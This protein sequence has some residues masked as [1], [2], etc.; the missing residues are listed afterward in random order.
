MSSAADT[1]EL[2]AVYQ[3]GFILNILGCVLCT[4][5]VYDWLLSLDEEAHYVWPKAKSGAS[6]LYLFSR[7]ATIVVALLPWIIPGS[8]EMYAAVKFE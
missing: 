5:L 1:A 6:V 3:Q 7:Y 8:D 4:F 2:V